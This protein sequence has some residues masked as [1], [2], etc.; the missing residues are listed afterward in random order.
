MHS[1]CLRISAK[2]CA[3]C[4]STAPCYLAL[5]SEDVQASTAAVDAV[6]D[7]DCVEKCW[8]ERFIR[9]KRSPTAKPHSK[10]SHIAA[11][12][13]SKR[14]NAL[15]TSTT[16]KWCTLCLVDKDLSAYTPISNLF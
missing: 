10:T 11:R 3:D 16:T 14:R 9:Q 4:G 2:L 5:P 12:R 13:N 7:E 1:R 15:G 6:D 8:H